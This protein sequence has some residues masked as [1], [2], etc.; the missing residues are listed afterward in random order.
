MSF[1]QHIAVSYYQDAISSNQV[2]FV[3]ASLV[4]QQF[5]RL[6]EALCSALVLRFPDLQYPSK[7]EMD[8]SRHVIGSH[9]L[10]FK[11]PFKHQVEIHVLNL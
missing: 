4:N 11:D 3:W 10:S 8:T 7:I 5:Q 2:P 9:C 6:K 1:P